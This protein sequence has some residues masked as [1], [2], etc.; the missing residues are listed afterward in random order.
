MSNERRQI[1]DMLA[2]GKVTAEEAERLLETIGDERPAA[3]PANAEP[4]DKATV[5][6]RYLCVLVNPKHDHGR[7][8]EQVN[9]KIPLGLIRA[10]MKLGAML[11]HH[12]QEKIHGHLHERGFNIDLKN[13]D[14][15]TLDEVL[16]SLSEMSI[17]VDDADE[18]V[19]IYCC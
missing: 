8:K 11:P 15:E 10:G 16:R 1:L 5:N 13:L 14:R 2:S 17:D 19:R 9:I 6:P 4:S 12:A 18:T 3:Q 7:H